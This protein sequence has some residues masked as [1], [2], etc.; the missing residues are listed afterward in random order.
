MST[1]PQTSLEEILSESALVLLDSLPVLAEEAFRGEYRLGTH[2]ILKGVSA[3]KLERLLQPKGW[4]VIWLIPR[5][6]VSA[7]AFD[8]ERALHRAYAR[9]IEQTRQQGGNLLEIEGIRRR[10]ILGFN[11]ITLWGK[12]FRIQPSQIAFGQPEG[13]ASELA[14]AS[15]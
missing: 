9:L 3:T 11:Y 10:K 8:P 15:P 14:S 13:R 2:R 6:T 5:L 1:R 4:H 7:F 12:R